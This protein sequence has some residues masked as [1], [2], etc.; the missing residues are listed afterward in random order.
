MLGSLKRKEQPWLLSFDFVYGS[1]FLCQLP[2]LELDDT[3]AVMFDGLRSHY[4]A[5]VILQLAAQLMGQ[6]A[7]GSDHDVESLLGM[8]RAGQAEEEAHRAGA[9]A[10][11]VVQVE[12]AGLER[13]GHGEQHFAVAGHAFMAVK[14]VHLA[15]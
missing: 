8:T 14:D 2:A 15:E 10:F 1:A 3:L 5:L 6:L 7:C 12:S 4:A 9:E 11:D 13:V